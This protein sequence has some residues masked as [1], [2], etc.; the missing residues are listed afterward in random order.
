VAALN[1]MADRV[2]CAC[3]AQLVNAIAP[4]MTETGGP[5]W[6]QTIFYPFAQMSRFGRGRVLRMALEAPTYQSRYF[7][8]MGP[9]DL[10]FT[11]EA[12]PYLKA[13]AIHDPATDAL[14]FFLLNRHLEE[15]LTLRIAALGFPGLEVETAETLHDGDLEATNTRDQ[16][17]RVRP[18][19]LD[20]IATGDDGLRAIL[21]PA[22]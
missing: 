7:D 1:K 21:P 17:N 22:S 11:I 18:S 15:T 9:Q 6:R 12:A 2:R 20:G 13:A 10:H 3:L 14:T 19:P 4:I 5:A 16:P 8:P